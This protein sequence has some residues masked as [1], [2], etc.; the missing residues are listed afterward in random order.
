MVRAHRAELVIAEIRLVALQAKRVGLDLG[1]PRA[2]L[3]AD[4]T[5]APAGA[6]RKVDIRLVADFPAMAASFVG[7]QHDALLACADRS[8]MTICCQIHL[9]RMTT[10]CQYEF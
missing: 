2:L 8:K 3:R 6:L 9:Y 1:A 5:I 10:C 7:F 4:R